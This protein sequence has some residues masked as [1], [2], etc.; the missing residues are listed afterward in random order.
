MLGYRLSGHRQIRTIA[1]GGWGP[2]G[3]RHAHLEEADH[4]PEAGAAPR[5]SAALRAGVCVRVRA[6][7]NGKVS[8][9]ADPFQL[10]QKFSQL[11]LFLYP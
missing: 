7:S 9:L 3:R 4:V 2:T 5:A 6:H 10:A 1:L 11:T 8:R